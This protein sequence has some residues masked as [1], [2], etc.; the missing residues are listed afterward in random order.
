MTKKSIV[1]NQG[2][3]QANRMSA[4]IAHKQEIKNVTK[5]NSAFRGSRGGIYLWRLDPREPRYY[6]K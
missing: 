6:I 5:H 4:I 1:Q 2:R 3:K